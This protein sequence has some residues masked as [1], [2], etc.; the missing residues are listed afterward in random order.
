[1]I[2]QPVMRSVATLKNVRINRTPSDDEF[3]VKGLSLPDAKPI[4]WAANDGSTTT[5]YARGGQA[6][7]EA[8]AEK[9]GLREQS[10][11][12]LAAL[13]RPSAAQK[14]TRADMKPAEPRSAPAI[15]TNTVPP[16][17]RLP[18]YL[19][20]LS[21]VLLAVGG[22]MIAKKWVAVRDARR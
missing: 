9:T 13:A 6:I 16:P 21:G 2:A 18:L 11:R 5:R 20:I 1:L 19:Y 14:Q 22:A 12:A 17:S 7:D 10:D 8:E 3:G 15:V 4:V